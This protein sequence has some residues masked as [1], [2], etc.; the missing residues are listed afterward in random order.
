ME[1]SLYDK[2]LRLAIQDNP[3]GNP[4]R[5]KNSTRQY[6]AHFFKLRHGIKTIG[7]A[8]DKLILN[9]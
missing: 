8:D 7:K 5:I 2:A 1:E 6:F 9:K 4:E 3:D